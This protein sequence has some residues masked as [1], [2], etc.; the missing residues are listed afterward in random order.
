M[1]FCKTQIKSYLLLF[2]IIA[3]SF[4]SVYGQ[5][6]GKIAGVVSDETSGEKLMGAN[7]IL[8]GTSLGAAT[9]INGDYYIIN[10]PPGKYKLIFQMLG[11]EKVII[12]DVNVS[13]NR[14]TTINISLKQ[15]S[16][17]LGG[18]VVVVAE[19]VVMKKDQ[20]SSVRN[21]TTDQIKALPVE[22]LSDVVNM[23][24]GVVAG[25]FRGGRANEVTYMVD[26]LI[27]DDSFNKT[28]R[29]VNVETDA[30][31]EL[32]VITGTF[33]AEYGNAMSGIV[34]AITKEGGDKFTGSVSVGGSNY[35]TGNKD[36]FKGLKDAEIRNKDYKLFLSG[37]IIKEYLNFV[38]NGRYQDNL[39]HLVGSRKFN[40]DDYSNFESY[41]TNFVSEKN[42]NGENVPFNTNKTYS[43]FT[44]LSVK[45]IP[46]VRTSLLYS[47]NWGEGRG[48]SHEWKYNPDGLGYT[49]ERSDMYAIQINHS[50]SS[51]I[52]YEAKASLVDTRNAYYLYENPLD[53]RYVSDYYRKI[54]GGFY[55]GGQ[56]KNWSETKTK[57]LNGKFDITWQVNQ[58]HILKTGVN[59][60][61]H[62]RDLFSAEIR[63]LYFNTA[64]ETKMVYDS[65][66]KKITYPYYIPVVMSDSTNFTTKYTAKP[67]EAAAYIQDKME[68]ENMVINLGVRF[69][70]FDPNTVCPT[71]WRNPDNSI[72]FSSE[73]SDKYSQ[74][75]TA[76]KSYQLSPRFGLSYQL[77]KAALLR[78]AYG[79][80]FQMPPL[81]ALYQNPNF[82]VSP[83]DLGTLMGNPNLRPQKTIQYEVGLWQ[84]LV[85][86]MSLEVAV[87]YRDIY[88]LLSTK[89]I[90]TYN[91]VRYGQYTNLDYGNVKGLELKYDYLIDNFAFY[92]NYTLQFTRGNADQP[93]QTFNR[94]G[95][96]LDPVK[97]L[98]RL[99]WDQRHTINASLS[100]TESNFGAT[101][102][103]YYNSG[104][105]YTWQPIIE[106]PLYLINLGYNNSV[107]PDKFQ[108][109]LRAFVDVYKNDLF[110]VR[111]NLLVLNLFDSLLGNSVYN[112]TGEPY[113]R[114]VKAVDVNTWKSDYNT[115]YDPIHNPGQY[116]PPREVKLSLDIRF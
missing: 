62:K 72:H 2:A 24:S 67:I 13:V 111:I 108:M 48:Y 74:Y 92:L 33:N 104:V 16:I 39:N 15:T 113:Q 90:Y 83:N 87:Y 25:H 88:D 38:F 19:K 52:F 84:E 107:I 112:D 73:N 91:S 59:Y 40:V 45:G 101:V 80:F 66:R 60:T 28:S 42:G 27:I 116:A 36:V 69:D 93:L 10:I 9:D 57:D 41:P 89:V 30:V 106:S 71:D 56:D 18:E 76:D 14:T 29:N 20:T 63:N 64:N 96:N 37:P 12:Q 7:V 23:Q 32:E 100:Y 35:I 102:T 95:G 3:L 34:N 114:I 68:F 75:P 70:Y 61:H 6:T 26:G 4:S 55:T 46:N 31:Q 85:K 110:S 49:H 8:D 79:H 21:V 82:R 103:A 98:Y 97:E 81:Y 17:Q 43:I 86:D 54:G 58:N 51:S 105:P 77:G 94:A 1:K 50:L 65:L 5:T 47:R 44:K 22:S 115:I 99:G 53:A 109:D 11:F 78:F